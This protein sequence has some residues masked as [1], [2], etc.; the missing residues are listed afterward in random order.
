[1]ATNI[2]EDVPHLVKLLISIVNGFHIPSSKMLGRPYIYSDKTVTKAFIV[3]VYFRLTSIRSLA[4][5][6]KDHQDIAKACGLKVM[7]PTYRTLSR[8]LKTLN[9][10]LLSFACQIVSVLVKYNLVSLKIVST[11][12][13]LCQAAGRASQKKALHI[14]ATDKDAS[15]GFSESRGFV[16][17]YKLHLT[18]TVLIKGK[19]IVPL[20]WEVTP[21]NR[22]DSKLLIS[23]ME[24]VNTLST[25]LRRRVSYSL[26]DKGYDQNVNYEWCRDHSLRFIT[27]VRRFK[28]QAISKIKLWAR[29][30]IDTVGGKELYKRRADNERL[31]AQFKD[32]FL[33]DPLPVR[34]IKAVS[35]YL[36]VMCVSYLLGVLYNHLNGR[37][38]RAIKSLVA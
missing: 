21:A 2:I 31:F 14:V 37:S 15:W 24:K 6:L 32:I 33:I 16:F 34:G 13:S 22:H 19:T 5:F 4:R 17:G 18:S 35:S 9:D 3:M 23:L 30:F 28:K 8:R 1:M 25:S 7:S 27:P 10:L 29:R 11:D 20:S 36:S 12:S 38:L 26:G